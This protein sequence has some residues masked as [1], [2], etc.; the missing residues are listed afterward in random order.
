[1]LAVIDTSAL[2]AVLINEEERAALV[3]VTRGAALVAPGS[4]HWEVGNAL[5]ALLK[6]RRA[7][8]VQVRNALAAYAAIPIRL[9]DVD[10]TL[11]LEVAS[12][13]GIY[14]YDAYLVAC[15]LEQRAPLLTLD[16]DL[17]RV[18]SAAGVALMEARK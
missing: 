2:V 18:A 12:E 1:M 9:V 15:A 7:T 6:R 5:S 10:L 13:H 3:R 17:A 16:R 4:V 11:S 14:A 8:L